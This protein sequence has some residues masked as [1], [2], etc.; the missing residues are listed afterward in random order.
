MARG[1]VFESG[2]VLQLR[3]KIV[4]PFVAITV[5]PAH[6]PVADKSNVEWFHSY[7]LIA[8]KAK[9]LEARGAIQIHC[10]IAS[11]RD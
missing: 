4:N 7:C 6:K 8:S 2:K 5:G 1:D 9:K 10:E 3:E 11:H